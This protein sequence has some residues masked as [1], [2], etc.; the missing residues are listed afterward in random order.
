MIFLFCMLSQEK[1][2]S[3]DA[4]EITGC[5]AA[6]ASS[7]EHG[8]AYGI[9]HFYNKNLF[10]NVLYV[11]NYVV[12]LYKYRR[13]L[14]W[15]FL[16]QMTTRTLVFNPVPCKHFCDCICFVQNM[17]LN[18]FFVCFVVDVGNYPVPVQQGGGPAPI[19]TSSPVLRH[20]QPQHPQTPPATK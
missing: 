8:N 17:C 20:L 19:E 1:S 18:D 4:G 13:K 12:L 14:D 3:R 7:R 15:T 5:A 2:Q 9:L 16:H 10:S 6:A 11:I